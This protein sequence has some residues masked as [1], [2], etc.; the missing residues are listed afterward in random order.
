[1]SDR[2]SEARVFRAPK[3]TRDVLPPESA[4]WEEL[5][6]RFGARMRRAGFGLVITPIFEDRALFARGVGEQTDVVS[7][8][9]YELEDKAGRRLA[10][11]PEMTAAVMR[12]YLEHRPPLVWKVWYWG[13]QFRYEAPQ[14]NRLR[15][16]HQMG[17][18]ALGSSDPELDAELIQLA[19]ESC[20]DAGLDSLDLRLNSLGDS[21]CRPAYRAAL[22]EYLG[23]RA[24]ELCPEHKGRF[25]ERPMRVLDCKTEAC[26]K[27]AEE[28][29]LPPDSLCEDCRV[30]FEAVQGALDDLGVPYRLDPKL[31]RGL[32]YYTKTAFELT[33]PEL[34]SAQDAVGGGGRY[35]G[36]AEALG[37]PPVPAVGFSLGVERLLAAVGWKLAGQSQEKS[38]FVADLTGGRQASRIAAELR[39]AGVVAH[40]SYDDRSLKSQLRSADRVAASLAVI[41]GPSELQRGVATLR[42]LADGTQEEIA[43]DQLSERVLEVLRN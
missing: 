2:N 3:G 24:L 5:T 29:P 1:V 18:E 30:H 7:K 27:V 39:K 40:R 31:V 19:Y 36:L 22:V 28:A 9:M 10:L 23:R 14:A 33:A 20:R 38:V 25:A 13:P 37:G 42:H 17:A 41:I 11:R 16:F 15:Q 26:R 21:K 12:A 34:G 32:D 4:A 35:D 8:E 6:A 43:L